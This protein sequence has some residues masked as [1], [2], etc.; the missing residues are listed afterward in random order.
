MGRDKRQSDGQEEAIEL[1]AG[2]SLN[3]LGEY[4]TRNYGTETKGMRK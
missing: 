2:G 1:G 4:R 3:G